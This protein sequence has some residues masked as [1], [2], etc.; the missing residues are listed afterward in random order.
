MLRWSLYVKHEP[1]MLSILLSWHIE[2]RFN[3][4][5]NL[6]VIN[7]VVSNGEWVNQKTVSLKIDDSHGYWKVSPHFM[8]HAE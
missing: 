3:G 8:R 4:L 7:I 1:E 5:Q 6:R 2:K